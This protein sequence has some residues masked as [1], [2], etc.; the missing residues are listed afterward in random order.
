MINILF[1]EIVITSIMASLLFVFIIFIKKVFEKIIDISIS[2]RLW[3]LLL[4]CLLRPLIPIETVNFID[5]NIPKATEE[6]IDNIVQ[7]INTIKG[8]QLANERVNED[9]DDKEKLSNSVF[10]FGINVYAFIWLCGMIGYFIY[11]FFINH[12]IRKMI[13]IS[14]ND[15]D[16]HTLKIFHQCKLKMGIK[17]EIPIRS[18][19]SIEQPCIYGF[20]KPIVLLSNNCGDKLSHSQKEYICIH[21]LSHY[22]RKDNLTNWLLISIK[23][24]YWFNPII[25]YAINRIKEESEVACDALALSYI[26]HDEHQGYAMTI[27]D[28]L[29]IVSKFR[30]VL[31]TVSITSGRKRIEKRINMIYDFKKSTKFKRII[32]Y[33]IAIM[34][35]SVGIITVYAVEN[36]DGKLEIQEDKIG[37]NIINENNLIADN[38]I[39]RINFIWPV[40][41]HETI[42]SVY[43]LRFH[44]LYNTEEVKEV[45]TIYEECEIG[46]IKVLEPKIEQDT[47]NNGIGFHNGIDI[48]APEDEKIVASE[49]GTIQY[50]GFEG[51]YGKMI[52]I[53]HGEED[54]SIYAHC[55]KLLVKEGE[56][57]TKGEE[58]AKV[59]TTGASTGPHLHF[60]IV[61]DN[62]IENPMEY[63]NVESSEDKTSLVVET[64]TVI[65]DEKAYKNSDYIPQKV[66]ISQDGV[67]VEGIESE[68][69]YL[70]PNPKLSF[71]FEDGQKF[72]IWNKTTDDLE[73]KGSR[74]PEN[75]KTSVSCEFDKRININKIKSIVVDDIEYCL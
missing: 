75:N 49:N 24:I 65:L 23:I 20:F 27:I 37:S 57:V 68:T 4:L 44:P 3:F 63:L 6:S 7:N 70:I 15:V 9:K 26:T 56:V 2:Y 41:N 12:K 40:P 53:K 16:D 43:G 1:K 59:G 45:N 50:S 67:I 14:K 11:I 47:L 74:T 36:I 5:C 21:E 35:A 8:V 19:E 42:T 18:I 10:N 55:N 58:I 38:N 60:S 52:I 28:L 72:I 64:K 25:I 62:K 54:Y 51:I 22:L 39:K 33:L 46:N 69:Q 32:S 61:I 73:M 71:I 31:T 17:S 48:A 13:A 66:T 29:D 30:Y 34:I